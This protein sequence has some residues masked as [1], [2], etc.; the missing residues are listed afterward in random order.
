MCR[1]NFISYVLAEK[2]NLAATLKTILP[3]LPRAAKHVLTE[4]LFVIL[5]TCQRLLFLF[6]ENGGAL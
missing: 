3:P 5:L 2:Q 4:L 1:Q 6:V